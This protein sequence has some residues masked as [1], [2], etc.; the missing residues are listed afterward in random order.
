MKPDPNVRAD[1]VRRM[2]RRRRLACRF[3]RFDEE[4]VE[5]DFEPRDERRRLNA[6]LRYAPRRFR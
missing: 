5:L 3:E 1:L 4:L 2:Q 6:R